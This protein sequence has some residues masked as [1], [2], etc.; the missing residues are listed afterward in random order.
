MAG[1]RVHIDKSGYTSLVGT[2]ALSVLLEPLGSPADVALSPSERHGLHI[3]LLTKHEAQ[4]LAAESKKNPFVGARFEV[5]D[6]V[7]VGLG[8]EDDKDIRFA[9]VVVNKANAL[10]RK[11]G[12]EIKDFH[13]TLS[14]PT[15]ASPEDF[16]HGL[17]TLCSPIDLSS[18][19]PTLLDALAQHYL[20]ASDFSSSLAA[21][22]RLLT[23]SPSSSRAF[24]RLTDASSR[25]SYHKLALL[26]CGRAWELANTGSKAREYA[27]KRLMRLGGVET[28]WGTTWFE[29]E[30][31][32]LEMMGEGV[33]MEL[34]RPWSGELRAE[35][36][37]KVGER[38]PPTLAVEA[39]LHPSIRHEGRDVKLMRNFRWIV[40]FYLAVS[41]IPRSASDIS[42]L[43]SPALGTRHIITLSVE[44][45]F[46]ASYFAHNP[47]VRI[48]FLPIKDLAAPSVEQIRLFIKLVVESGER[49]EPVL[50]HC[51]GGKG[52]AGTMLAAWLVAFGFSTPPSPLSEWRYPAYPAVEALRLLRVIR[53][54]SVEV[55]AQEAVLRKY[56]ARISQDG[57]PFPLPPASL[58]ISLP[59]EITGTLSSTDKPDLLILV[60]LPGSGKSTFR[61]Q[62][63]FRDASFRHVSGDEDGGS[64]AVLSAA[65]TFR[66]GASG[67]KLIID[68]CSPSSSSRRGLLRLAHRATQPVC[69]FFDF[70]ASTCIYRAQQRPAHPS[71]PPGPR[72][73]A[74]MKQFEA[75]LE[76]PTLDEGFEAVVVVRTE[77][78]ARELLDRLAGPV[79][80]VKFPRTPHLF[81]LGAATLDYTVLPSSAGSPS[82]STSLFPSLS[83]PTRRLFLTVTEKLDGANL[84]FSLSSSGTVLV[85]NRSHYLAIRAGD[86]GRNGEQEQFRRLGRWMGEREGELRRLLGAD[87]EFPKRWVLYG[88]WMAAT[89]RCVFTSFL[90]ADPPDLVHFVLFAF[91][92]S[93]S[94]PPQRPLHRPHL[95]LHAFDLYDRLTRTF[96]PY[97]LLLAR[98]SAFAPSIPAVPLLF[99]GSGAEVQ[100][101]ATR[102]GLEGMVQGRSAFMSAETGLKEGRREGVYV[103]IEDE[104]KVVDRSKVVRSDFIA[105]NEHWSK[106]PQQL[107]V[108]VSSG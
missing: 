27:M 31:G 59:L 29:H 32:Q 25:L 9:V 3:T 7:P 96:L 8:G 15:R 33:K 67:D 18:A 81:D 20:L 34:V 83:D 23:L 28:E 79:G 1:L 21:S 22:I 64:S 41:S 73:I 92:S 5:A 85:Q 82:G 44:S 45:P 43:A 47:Q 30:G 75:Q 11:A 36:R 49:D 71:L 51:A 80:L 106:G 38:E 70:P 86:E 76:P 65:S 40:P 56:Y 4:R 55:G 46:P 93:G 12:L 54:Q 35:V 24:I 104:K 10:R 50:V 58:T 2:S 84:A 102:E 98:L 105:G 48:T 89:H 108:I 19:S 62:L 78:A 90:L 63:L 95:P 87:E 107:N 72:V 60:G 101:R 17:S 57:S 61:R 94:F 16:P 66:G 77:E 74:A 14:T 52:R 26:A 68:R 99:R 103:R 13:I 91:F 100:E 97:P 42:L 37:E 53:P 39:R 6:V 88:E 69:V